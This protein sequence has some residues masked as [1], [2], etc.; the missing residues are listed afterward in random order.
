VQL[1]LSLYGIGCYLSLALETVSRCLRALERAQVISKE[2][3]RIHIRD[4]ARLIALARDAGCGG[5]S[6]NHCHA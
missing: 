6:T 3:R 2:G 1:P 5:R 4:R